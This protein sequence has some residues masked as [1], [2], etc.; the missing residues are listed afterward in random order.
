MS[1]RVSPD[2]LEL[3]TDGLIAV[4]SRTDVES[5]DISTTL[6]ALSSLLT[7]NATVRKFQG[8]VAVSFD[9]FNE[10]PREIYEIPQI[11]RFCTELDRYF[12]YWLYFLSTDDSSL[13]MITFCL[14]KVEKKGP[15]LVTLDN[16]DLGRFLHS[17]FTAMNELFDRHSLDTETNRA[18]SEN[19]LRYFNLG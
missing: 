5:N 13:K 18:I 11:R 9:G 19:I 14:C 7:D 8:S 12:P 16:M 15:G 2:E 17:H 4:V 1:R 10:D 6:D 3:G